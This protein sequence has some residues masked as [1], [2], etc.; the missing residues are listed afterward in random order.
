MSKANRSKAVQTRTYPEK[1]WK[2]RGKVVDDCLALAEDRAGT[3][4]TTGLRGADPCASS[5]PT[6][7]EVHGR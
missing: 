2:T 1:P 4:P 6:T 3:D 5:Q 7:Y